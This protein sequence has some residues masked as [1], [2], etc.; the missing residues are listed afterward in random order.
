MSKVMFITGCEFSQDRKGGSGMKEEK[1]GGN[2]MRT[3]RKG[4]GQDMVGLR[5]NPPQELRQMGGTGRRTLQSSTGGFAEHACFFFQQHSILIHS[6]HV[7]EYL[8]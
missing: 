5:E 4:V 8:S 1:R 2:R 6:V 3:G 7:C